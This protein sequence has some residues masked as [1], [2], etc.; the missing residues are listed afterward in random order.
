M[1]KKITVEKIEA[2]IENALLDWQIPGGAVAI[3][4][5]GEVVSCR[6]YGVRELGAANAVNAE[7]LFGIGSCSKAFTAAIVGS[8]VDDGRLNWDDKVVKYLPEFKLYDPWITNQVT[9]RDMLSHRLGIRRSIRVMNRDRVFN[10]DDYIRR[11]EFVRP[12]GEFRAR[13]TYDNPQFLVAAKIAELVSGTKWSRLVQQRIFDPLG[14]H[15]SAATYQAARAMNTPNIASPHTNL[16]GGFVPAELRV[17]DPV[18]PI[19]WTDYGENAA[20]SILSN[21]QDMTRWLQL[22]LEGGNFNNQQILSREVLAEMTSPQMII[23]PA[24]SEMD[25][26]LAVGL[27]TNLMAYGLGWYVCDY[28]GYKMVFHPGQLHGFVAAVAFLPQLNVGGV[29][30]LNTYQ[31]MLHAMLGYYLFDAML[32]FERDYS[33]EMITLIRQWRSGAEMGV[34]QMLANRPPAKM[35]VLPLEQLTGTYSSALFGEVVISQENAQLSCQYGETPLFLADL[36][37]WDGLTFMVN[38]KN[39]INPAEFLTFLQDDQGRVNGLA[40]K[41]VDIFQ[42]AR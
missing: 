17:L 38:Y 35:P 25:S 16:D 14:M 7:T 11:M 5:R 18:Q 31:T 32:G 12:A 34:Q 20:G 3:I 22:L 33:A 10:S 30:L 23:K 13:F 28:R 27:Q 39:K 41:D 29:I 2:Y 21:I 24:E 8:L 4:D 37:P 15:S 42:R 26:L 9:I 19:P 6:G 36:E 1:E 40:I